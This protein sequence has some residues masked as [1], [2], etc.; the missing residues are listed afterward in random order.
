M[1]V[2]YKGVGGWAGDG[3]GGGGEWAEDGEG[4]GVSGQEVGRVVGAGGP[5]HPVVHRQPRYIQ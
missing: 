5:Y 2:V 4:D 1:S 3:E